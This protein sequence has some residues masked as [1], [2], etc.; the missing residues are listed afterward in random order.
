M[1]R[2]RAIEYDGSYTFRLHVQLTNKKD[3]LNGSISRSQRIVLHY[4]AYVNTFLRKKPT[5]YNALMI[6]QFISWWYGPGWNDAQKYFGLTGKH[7]YYGLS[8]AT[9]MRTLFDPWRRIVTPTDN[10]PIAA[11]KAWG[12]NLVSR[13]VG[14]T[15]RLATL[16]VAGI[17]L[18]GMGLVGVLILGLWF[19]WPLAGPAAV[20]M[21]IIL[22]IGL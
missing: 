1:L 20:I 2:I 10:D 17:L 21:G 16:I 9:L 13:S 5:W 12:D 18:C 7:I 6:S 14:A 3:P 15:I 19:I 11:L 8:V 4:S 22:A